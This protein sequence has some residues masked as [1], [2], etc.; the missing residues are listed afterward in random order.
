[1][2]VKHEREQIAESLDWKKHG[3]PGKRQSDILVDH[4]MM[5]SLDF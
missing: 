3:L 1:M 4:N 2:R 5:C